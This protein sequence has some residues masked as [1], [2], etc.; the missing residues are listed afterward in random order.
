MYEKYKPRM[1]G[2]GGR[3]PCRWW[4]EFLAKIEREQGNLCPE[5]LIHLRKLANLRLSK[6]DSLYNQKKA[7]KDSADRALKAHLDECKFVIREQ[8]WPLV[9]RRVFSAGPSATTPP[10]DALPELKLKDTGLP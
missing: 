1:R 4:E 6:K 8:F 9:K 5:C 2:K 10:I 3:D 7:T